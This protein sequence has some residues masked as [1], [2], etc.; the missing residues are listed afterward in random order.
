MSDRAATTAALHKTTPVS[1]GKPS[2]DHLDRTS[3]VSGSDDDDDFKT[4]EPID[5]VTLTKRTVYSGST[6]AVLN[7]QL[8]TSSYLRPFFSTSPVFPVQQ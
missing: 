3:E 7:F 4:G 8:K 6:S 5:D 2:P 1:E